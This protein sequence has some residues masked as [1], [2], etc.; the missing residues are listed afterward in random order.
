MT[1]PETPPVEPQRSAP[2]APDATVDGEG[3]SQ[4]AGQSEPVSAPHVPDEP[5]ATQS[6][7]A[8]AAQPVTPQFAAQPG[9]P[10]QQFAA[11][12]GH[13]EQ[14]F[15][16]QPGHPEQQFA[17]QPDHPEQQAPESAYPAHQY[18]AQSG[19]PQ[20]YPQAYD[21]SQQSTDGH[22]QAF[23]PSAAAPAQARQRRPRFDENGA[24]YGV[25]PFTLRETIFVILAALVLVSSFLPFIGGVY[26]DLFGYTSLWAPAPW[27]AIPGALLLAVAAALIVIRRLRPSQRL[28][29]GSLSVDQFASAMAISTAGFYVG[30]L[31]LVL[32]FSAWFG[33]N[34]FGRDAEVI[35][36][37]PGLILG[38]IF[39]LASLVPTTFAPF[40]APLKDD[41]AR[42]EETPAHPLAREANPVPRRPR[43][44][45]PEAPH[46]P[47]VHSY[48][49]ENTGSVQ[50]TPA[51]ARPEDFAAYRRKSWTPEPIVATD[52][53]TFDPSASASDTEGEPQTEILDSRELADASAPTPHETPVLFTNS[54][55]DRDDDESHL[56]NEPAPV[57]AIRHVAEQEILGDSG[58][59]SDI[60][61]AAASEHAPM[62][63]TA[64]TPPVV[65]TQPFWVYSPVPLPIVDE[66]SG[67]T[68]FEIGP[69]AWALAIVDRGSE[70]VIRHDDGRVGVLRQL[71]GIM[72]G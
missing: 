48:S 47:E 1:N 25:G 70:L 59:T 69:S 23:A 60:G 68:V 7:A 13:P 56:G 54:D 5:H 44:V 55:E 28:R 32:G 50:L 14:Q 19:Y 53:A 12:P 42:R 51:D 41:F 34:A 49:Q 40:T 27:I 15:A 30:A 4:Q 46:A 39:A 35:A 3:L 6:V 21:G 45:R 43:P 8:P 61:S 71:T 62:P 9:H 24:A 52:D 37:G 31:F 17:A 66:T 20:P 18:A 33:G 36:P 63:A 38:L 10:E 22:P 29:V 11:Q 67:A 72:R 58:A 16:A 26:A 57:S 2:H 64:Q 65:S